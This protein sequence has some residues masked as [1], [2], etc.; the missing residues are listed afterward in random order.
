MKFLFLLL[1]ILI[2]TFYQHQKMLKERAYLM[3]EAIKNKEYNFRLA[4]DRLFFGE[5]AMQETLNE[6]GR[7]I[8]EVVSHNEV[9]SWQ[10]LTRVLTHEIMNA[11]TP[12]QSISQAYLNNPDIKGSIYEEGIRAIHDTSVGLAT[13]VDSY[14]KLSQMQ[15]PV[16]KE[17]SLAPFVASLMPLYPEVEWAVDIPSAATITADEN[18]LRQVFIN[19]LKNAIEAHAKRISIAS[20][21]PPLGAGGFGLCLLISNDGDIIPPEVRRD[22]FVPFFSTKRSGSGIGLSVSQQ[23]LIMQNMNISLDDSSVAGYHTTFRIT[24][25]R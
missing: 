5:K 9:E 3:R 4:T 23:M 1:I 20:V 19:I 18:L 2:Y 15:K 13:F 24:T 6:L 8:S 14:R 21:T 17:I 10:R 7:T 16:M 25:S 22:M 12:I 11:A